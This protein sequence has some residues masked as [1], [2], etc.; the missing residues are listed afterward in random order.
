MELPGITSIYALPVAS[1][2]GYVREM[3]LVGIRPLVAGSLIPLF[4]GPGATASDECSQTPEGATA[5]TTLSF[6]AS[7]FNFNPA[8]ETAFVI[9]AAD[10]RL[11]L[12]GAKEPPFPKVKVKSDL[13]T[14][15][16]GKAG[17]TFTVEWASRMIECD[18]LL[19][20]F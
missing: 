17:R 15:A 13:S 8:E 3:S 19:P 18:A 12:V 20:S 6:S 9:L 5:K 1:L 7:G 10:E 14:P 16:E 2:P 11:W 4:V